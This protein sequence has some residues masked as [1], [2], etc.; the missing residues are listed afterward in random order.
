MNIV[1]RFLNWYEY[2]IIASLL[3]TAIILY[4]QIPHTIAAADC[5]FTLGIGIVHI[6]PLIDFFLYGIDLLELLPIINI[7]I[8]LV[9]KIRHKFI[10]GN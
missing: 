5:F 10:K 7:T 8:L 4:M 6:H 9:A 3:I 2:H 1:T